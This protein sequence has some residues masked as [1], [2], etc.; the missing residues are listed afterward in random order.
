MRHTIQTDFGTI[1]G[2][3]DLSGDLLVTFNNN[4]V[5][6]TITI[7]KAQVFDL[8]SF[9]LQQDLVNAL[10]K[11]LDVIIAN[12]NTSLLKKLLDAAKDK[13]NTLHG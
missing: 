8:H 9:I 1:M 5:P 13:Q 3:S 10:S 12:G 6:V 4:G 7:T 2:N 11:E